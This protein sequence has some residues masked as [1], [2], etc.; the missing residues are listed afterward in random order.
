M[1]TI[2]SWLVDI[3]RHFAIELGSVFIL[4]LV[5]GIRRRLRRNRR[6]CVEVCRLTIKEEEYQMLEGKE[7]E[8]KIGNIGAYSVDVKGNGE[9]EVMV[10]VNINL[11]EQL[12]KLAAKTSTPI[13]DKAIEWIEALLVKEVPEASAPVA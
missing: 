13:D 7:I 3:L 11:I 12:K 2:T 9:L 4:I 8:G 10:G 6:Q 5:N 1:R